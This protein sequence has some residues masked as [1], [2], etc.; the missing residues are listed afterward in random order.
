MSKINIYCDESCHLEHD[1]HKIMVLGALLCPQEKTRQI[2]DDVRKIKEARSRKPWVELKW[3]RVSPAGADVY[4]DVLDYFFANNDLTFRGLIIP[5]KTI[6]N[7]NA[8]EQTHETWYYKMFYITLKKVIEA[9]NEYY[10]YM[11]LQGTTSYS[12]AQKLLEVLRN[13]FGDYQ[14]E[15]LKRVQPVRSEEVQQLQVCDL[16]TGIVSYANRPG[17]LSPAKKRLV[18]FAQDKTHLAL[19]DST[20][21][22]ETKFSLLRWI[23]REMPYE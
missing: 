12:K 6:L 4:F 15:L 9:P 20:P 5:D 3:N 11:D 16:L 21:Y 23:P 7:H 10:I 8:F 17:G 1:E 19:T 13:K 22:T 2:A 14:M 18:Q